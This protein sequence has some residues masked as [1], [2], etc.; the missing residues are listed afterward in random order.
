MADTCVYLG[1]DLARYGWVFFFAG[2]FLLLLPL[3]PG[4]GVTS[5]MP[6]APRPSSK[7]PWVGRRTRITMK[8]WTG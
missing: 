5:A 2:A 1:P 4:L 7:R 3:A 8:A 6:A